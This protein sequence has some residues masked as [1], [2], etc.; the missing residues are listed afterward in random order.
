MESTVAP[1]SKPSPS[2]SETIDENDE[3]EDP[4][5]GASESV[6]GDT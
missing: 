6:Q 3:S 2:P 5:S 1:E 4:D